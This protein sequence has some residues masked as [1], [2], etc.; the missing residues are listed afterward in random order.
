MVE[1]IRK[2]GRVRVYDAQ[3]S[4]ETML[5]AAEALFAEQGFHGASM[6]AIAKASGYNKSLLF[7][8]FGDKLSLYTEV[9]KR[10]DRDMSTLLARV[11]APLF[12]DDTIVSDAKLFR[13]FLGATFGTVFDYMVDHSQLM[14][15]FNWEQAEGGQTVAQIAAH[16]E[17]DDLARFEAIFSRARGAGLVRPDLDVVVMVLLV[18]QIC[19]S[20]PAALPVYQLLLGQRDFSSGTTLAH[21]REQIIDLL[22]AWV[23]P[24]QGD[25][26][27]G[28]SR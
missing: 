25:E 18:A 1:P 13:V 10:A 3:K 19:W 2:R 15:M 24:D 22:I 26:H 4:R 28:E 16:F 17:P 11:F 27:L 7:Q 6:D 5:N 14:R 8:Y 23:S 12:V 9:L 21:L 20:V